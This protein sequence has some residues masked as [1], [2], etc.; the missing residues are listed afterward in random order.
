VEDVTRNKVDPAALLL[1]VVGA[2]VTPLLT[3]GS[4]YAINTLIA[5]IA[6]LVI[7]SYSLGPGVPG[8][9]SNNLQ[10][11]AVALVIGLI[12]SVAVAWP[13]QELYVENY[14]NTDNDNLKGSRAAVLA[15]FIGLF[16]AIGVVQYLRRLS[17][18]SQEDEPE[19]E[20]YPAIDA[21]LSSL[22]QEIATLRV[23]CEELQSALLRPSGA[24]PG[25][26]EEDGT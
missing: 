17:A 15:L 14:W 16:V 25:S 7:A 19:T 9:Y 13:V 11:W 6:L 20:S 24:I 3:D 2:A 18:M 26:K 10:R 1:A 4:W 12:T 8:S 5:G 23:R 21:R 22:E